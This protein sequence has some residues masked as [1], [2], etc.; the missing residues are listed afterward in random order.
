[1][2]ALFDFWESSLEKVECSRKELVLCVILIT[3]FLF[4]SKCTD[5]FD[6]P[7][8]SPLPEFMNK[9]Y[10]ERSRNRRSSSK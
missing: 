2:H 6:P 9:T 7:P 4:F 10:L 1:M 3:L 8:L 5:K